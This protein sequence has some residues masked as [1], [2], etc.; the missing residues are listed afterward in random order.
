MSLRKLRLLTAGES[1]GPAL[2]TILEG[3]PAH[4]PISQE[5]LQ[6]LMKRRQLGY[7]RGARMKIE[8]DQVEITAGLRFGKTLGSPVSL[9]IRNRDFQNW[10]EI[11]NPWQEPSQSKRAVHRPRPGHADL[12]GGL[13]YGEQDLRNIL[14][15][16]SARESAARTAAGALCM[17]LLEHAGVEIA[18]HVIRIGPVSLGERNI[19]W[20]KIQSVQDS[21]L[22]RCTDEVVE[23]QMVQ[24][25]DSAQQSKETLGGEF[26]VVARNVPPGLGSHIQWDQKLDGRIAQA[27]LSV[28]AVKAVTVG[29][30]IA[31]AASPGSQAHDEIYFEKSRGFFR[32][33][34]HAG[35]LEGGI[36]NG[37]EIRVTGF[38]KPLST[39]MKP[40]QSVDVVTKKAEEAVVE[41]SDT[42]AV[43]AAG[44]VAEAMIAL[45]L[46]DALLEKFPGDTLEELL[47]ALAFYRRELSNY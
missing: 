24:Q 42:C 33:T 47:A 28:P 15:R 27:I 31:Q 19:S 32:K 39:L 20:E 35:G 10:E 37:E 11:M 2:T 41:R 6:H 30:A 7:G 1:H 40:L 14:E 3:L 46:A 26:E 38:M 22:L 5:K 29:D 17:Q 12:A 18:S 23:Q 44:V 34:N 8:T 45:V 43:P 4:V 21:D 13:K 25:V 36:T 16:A 9:L